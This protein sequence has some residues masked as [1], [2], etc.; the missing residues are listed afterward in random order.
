MKVEIEITNDGRV[1]IKKKPKG[2]TLI[3]T[4]HF[5]PYKVNH[6]RYHHMTTIGKN[7]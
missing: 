7:R 2:I 3:V 6:L 5:E 1:L 4:H